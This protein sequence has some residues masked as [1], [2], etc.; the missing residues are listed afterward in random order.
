[1]R[2]PLAAL[3][4]GLLPSPR[5]YARVR[6][7][8]LSVPGPIAGDPFPPSASGSTAVISEFFDEVCPNR[9]IIDPNEVNGSLGD[10]SAATIFQAWLDKLERTEGRCVEIKDHTPQ[11]SDSWYVLSLCP[12][13]SSLFAQPDLICSGGVKGIR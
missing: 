11:I 5:L 9:I 2:V 3:P 8:D 13:F 12:P 1:M 4:S 7:P 10:A 6:D